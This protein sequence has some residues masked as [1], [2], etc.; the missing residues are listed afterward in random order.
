MHVCITWNFLCI[1]THV[2]AP[3]RGKHTT[4]CAAPARDRARGGLQTE[5]ASGEELKAAREAAKASMESI[6]VPPPMDCSIER[7]SMAGCDLIIP[8][9]AY[10]RRC[11]HVISSTACPVLTH[12][13]RIHR[14]LGMGGQIWERAAQGSRHP[15]AS[16]RAGGCWKDICISWRGLHGDPPGPDA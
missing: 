9:A 8:V 7:T 4:V 5:R 11:R 12:P 13:V 15:G 16:T 10:F 3:C 1:R 2:V 6:G 14:T